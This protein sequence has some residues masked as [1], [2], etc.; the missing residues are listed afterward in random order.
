MIRHVIVYQKLSIN[1]R[2]YTNFIIEYSS[3][4]QN[5]ENKRQQKTPL[6]KNWEVDQYRSD[7]S[8]DLMLV[9]C[10]EFFVSKGSRFQAFVRRD[11]DVF[12]R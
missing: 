1:L 3:A 6:M 11:S 5:I 2:V 4:L 7:L 10:V 9:K 8:C 12:A